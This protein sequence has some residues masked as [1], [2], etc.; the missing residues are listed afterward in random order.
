[1]E[2][3]E[4]QVHTAAGPRGLRDAHHPSHSVRSPGR[5]RA[6]H[7]SVHGRHRRVLLFYPRPHRSRFHRNHNLLGHR[8]RSLQISHMEKFTRTNLRAV[9]SHFRHHR[10]VQ[11][12]N[13][14]V[15]RTL[16]P[17]ADS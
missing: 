12:H 17:R 16:A 15:Q 13:I 10:C 11:K 14:R 7:R 6:H 3:H 2:L 5:G 4:G 9:R 1:M 8:F